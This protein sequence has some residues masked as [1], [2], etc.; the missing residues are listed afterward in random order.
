MEINEWYENLGFVKGFVTFFLSK[1][2]ANSHALNG[3]RGILFK[4]LLKG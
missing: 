4:M 1:V 2:H 3:A